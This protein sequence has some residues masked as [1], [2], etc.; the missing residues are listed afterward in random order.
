MPKTKEIVAPVTK[1]GRESVDKILDATLVLLE[2]TGLA[3]ITTNHI[4]RESGVQVGSIYR[5]FPNKEAILVA[6]VRRWHE[7][8]MDTIEQFLE[9]DPENLLFNELIH[10]L[11]LGSLKSDYVH[12]AAY[13]EIFMGAST[14][15]GLG[16][17]F[18][19]HQ[20]RVANRVADYYPSKN[21]KS[22]KEI[23]EFCTFLHSMISTALSK[24]ASQQ[25]RDRT[26]YAKWV[27]GMIDGAIEV[28]ECEQCVHENS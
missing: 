18:A 17:L 27:F 14:V 13:Q 6:L 19:Q 2:T 1:Q 16:D 21:Q 11:F 3:N 4:A 26:R 15:L 28:F 5:F 24:A 22:R 8:I 12:S 10:G 23:V 9:K 20:Q 25:A 7:H